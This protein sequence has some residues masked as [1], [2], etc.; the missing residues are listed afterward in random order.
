MINLLLGRTHSL[1][2]LL[3]ESSIGSNQ[4]E[5]CQELDELNQRFLETA[6]TMLSEINPSVF[7]LDDQSIQGIYASAFP[8]PLGEESLEHHC[9]QCNSYGVLEQ[10]IAGWLK[11]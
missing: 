7:Q 11:A 6:Q 3:K 2:D 4:V 5:H 10:R 1:I 9:N 8:F